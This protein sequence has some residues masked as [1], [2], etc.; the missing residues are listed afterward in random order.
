MG[1]AP[2]E[3]HMLGQSFKYASTG[4]NDVHVI[5]KEDQ[6]IYVNEPYM[7]K[8]NWQ[9]EICWPWTRIIKDLTYDTES[10][11]RMYEADTLTHL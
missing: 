9:L 1:M 7:S 8:T 6:L 3:S 5:V 10:I 11:F 2:L 4:N